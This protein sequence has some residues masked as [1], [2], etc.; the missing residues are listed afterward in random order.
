MGN[1]GTSVN[2]NG[3][4]EE[5]LIDDSKVFVF[6]SGEKYTGAEIKNGAFREKD[7]RQKTMTIAEEKRALAEEKRAIDAM[8]PE[9]DRLAEQHSQMA[10]FF[11]KNPETYQEFAKQ[12]GIVTVDHSKGGEPKAEP[13]GKAPAVPPAADPLLVARIS[14]LE[15]QT[16]STRGALEIENFARE[17]GVKP[18]WVEKEILPIAH[19]ELNPGLGARARL[20]A[21]LQLWQIRNGEPK[22][23]ELLAAKLRN[24]PP[25]SSGRSPNDEG[26]E[27]M[28]AAERKKLENAGGAMPKWA[29]S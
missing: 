3:T 9:I 22:A 13:K 29:I 26:Y 4:A 21:A 19:S 8:K 12:N 11:A 6:P 18:E 7:Y 28:V 10:D 15:Q 24:T 14:R 25:G 27:G 23:N 1:E 20:D 17:I 2:Q 5:I 16:A